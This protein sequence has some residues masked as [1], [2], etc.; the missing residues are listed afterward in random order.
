M[1]SVASRKGKERADEASL[2][3]VDVEGELVTVPEGSGLAA[4]GL[5]EL[6]RRSTAGE[7][8]L[9]TQTRSRATSLQGE[10]SCVFACKRSSMLMRVIGELH[11]LDPPDGELSV[12][13]DF[14]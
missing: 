7:G 9:P 11:T 8:K 10:L 12:P 6:V 3:E 14:M 2:D 5:R 13:R 4:K 1:R